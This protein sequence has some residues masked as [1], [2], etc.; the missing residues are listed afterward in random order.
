[1]KNIGK[2][3][4]VIDSGLFTIYMLNPK[5]VKKVR[6]NITKGKYPEPQIA[7]KEIELKDILDI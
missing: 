4:E 3:L 6:K 5:M 7:L 2:C 1:M